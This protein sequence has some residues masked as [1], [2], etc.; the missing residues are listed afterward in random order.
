MNN[1]SSNSIN[2]EFISIAIGFIIFFVCVQLYCICG[3]F[4]YDRY[5][6]RRNPSLYIQLP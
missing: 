3:D 2:N 1:S 4:L 6:R 5:K